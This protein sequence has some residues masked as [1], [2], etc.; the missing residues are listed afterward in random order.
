[1]NA[2]REYANISTFQTEVIQKSLVFVDT[3]QY[4]LKLPRQLGTAVCDYQLHTSMETFPMTT[5]ASTAAHCGTDLHL[6][7]NLH[8]IHPHWC[9]QED[10]QAKRSSM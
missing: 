3:Y 9:H 6:C 8:V 7:F 1:M 2:T 4:G 10:K 5:S